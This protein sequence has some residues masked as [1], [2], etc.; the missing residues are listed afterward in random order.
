MVGQPVDSLV[1]DLY[2]RYRDAV[3]ADVRRLTD[4][5]TA[6]DVVQETFVRLV[7]YGEPR[8]RVATLRY[9]KVIA[10]NVLHDAWRA[11]G[12]S[13]RATGSALGR[14]AGADAGGPTSE[15][16][17]MLERL[18]E[19]QREALLLTS[20][21]GLTNGEASRA[22]DV[23][24]PSVSHRRTRALARLRALADAEAPSG[25]PGRRAELRLA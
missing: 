12:R 10:R 2:E 23:S 8:L 15:I 24:E 14:A 19:S 7:R 18:P 1:Q 17:G 4:E 21:Y 3:Y 25:T 16:R 5:H 6:E 9:L 11:Q 13:S 20:A 22:L